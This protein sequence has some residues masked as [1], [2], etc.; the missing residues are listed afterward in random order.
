MIKNNKGLTLI[1]LLITIAI[2]SILLITVWGF[3]FQGIN[4]SKVVANKTLLQQEANNIVSSITRIHQTTSTV[5]TFQLDGNSTANN[6]TSFKVIGKDIV[7]FD[8][9]NFLY[10]IYSFD[11][12]TNSEQLIQDN[13]S[14]N[15]NTTDLGLKIII[16][17][18]QHNEILYEVKTIFSRI[19]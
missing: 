1:E 7:H 11:I 4:F 15:P 17:D 14:I 18:K 6:I 10:S 2:S 9:P 12:N 13:Q 8:S 3:L 19:K 16:R 5:Y